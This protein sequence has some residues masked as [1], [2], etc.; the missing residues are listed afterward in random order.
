MRAFIAIELPEN[1]KKELAKIQENLKTYDLDFRWVE[2]ENLHLTL[3]FLG[4]IDEKQ[5]PE[6]KKTIEEIVSGQKA[7]E[8]SFKTLGFFPG[9]R[10][11]RVFFISTDNQDLL[12]TLVERLEIKLEKIGFPAEGRFKSHLTLARIKSSK[13]LGTLL[14]N[15]EKVSLEGVF[16]VKEIAVYES[17]LKPTGPVYEKIARISLT[18]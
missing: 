3:K 16:T 4:K 17:R 13:N 11:P 12:Q 6:I 18:E 7:F 14:Q 9:I 10:K 1:L 15:L 8:L 5:L 2:P